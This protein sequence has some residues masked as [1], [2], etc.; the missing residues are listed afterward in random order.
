MI[1]GCTVEAMQASYTFTE[2][3]VISLSEKRLRES[4]QNTVL[5]QVSKNGISSREK[6][7]FSLCKC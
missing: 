4:Y 6:N 2:V 7:R 1:W 5:I 3:R